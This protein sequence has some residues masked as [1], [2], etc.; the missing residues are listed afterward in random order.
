MAT[1]IEIEAKVLISEQDYKR[2]IK[3]YSKEN[4][5]KIK[6]VNYYI[7][8]DSL[9]LKKYGIGLRIREKGYYVLT[10][11]APMGEGLLEKKE[12]ITEKQFLDFN[13]KNI[14]PNGD[15]KNFLMML[16]VDISK[17]KI[18]TK[19]VT[20]RIEID[21]YASGEVFSIDKNTYNGIVDYELEMEGESLE[22]AKA[23]LKAR[24]EELNIEYKD[25]EK[26]KQV[27]AMITIK[28]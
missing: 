20:D 15:V 21:N 7:D 28:K 9:Y 6:Q 11:K 24:C 22:R 26:S 8:T 3:F 19:L 25:N 1:N 13:D 17:L 2:V 18:Q 16:G 12:S 23:A 4:A 27:R 5:N 10:L 14:F